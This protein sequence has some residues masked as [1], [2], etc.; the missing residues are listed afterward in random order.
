MSSDYRRNVTRHIRNQHADEPDMKHSTFE[1]IDNFTPRW[2]VL[3]FFLPNQD[4][5]IKNDNLCPKKFLK[6]STFYW[7]KIGSKVEH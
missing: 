6:I 4:D 1:T 3:N 2:R 5:A 7:N